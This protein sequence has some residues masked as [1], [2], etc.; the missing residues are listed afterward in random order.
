[1]PTAFAAFVISSVWLVAAFRVSTI[2]QTS[3]IALLMALPAVL[4]A[5]LFLTSE[6]TNQ[7]NLL[8]NALLFLTV[9]AILSWPMAQ[10]TLWSINGHLLAKRSMPSDRIGLILASA[11][12]LFRGQR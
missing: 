6:N 8:L 12:G 10:A 7:L 9:G 1:M 11:G 4:P 5:A 3:I 2:Y